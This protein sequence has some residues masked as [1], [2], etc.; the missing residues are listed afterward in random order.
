MLQWT[1]VR[2][3]PSGGGDRGDPPYEPYVPPHKNS[4]PP[5][6]I[7]KLSPLISIDHW[8]GGDLSDFFI[9]GLIRLIWQTENLRMTVLFMIWYNKQITIT[10]TF[11]FISPKTRGIHVYIALI[12]SFPPHIKRHTFL[13]TQQQELLIITLLWVKPNVFSSTQFPNEIVLCTILMKSYSHILEEAEKWKN[14][15]IWKPKISSFVIKKP[16]CLWDVTYFNKV[17]FSRNV[18]SC[19]KIWI[20]K[21]DGSKDLQTLNSKFDQVM[22]KWE[23]N[24]EVTFRILSVSVSQINVLESYL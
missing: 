20:K 13:Y 23:R 17:T 9:I 15:K 10:H 7:E 1:Q 8:G 18:R 11:I 16:P 21:Q 12:G 6:K 4:V 3:F 14:S 2:V 22:F 24:F 5:Y 19:S